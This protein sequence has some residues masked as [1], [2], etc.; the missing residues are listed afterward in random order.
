MEMEVL[1]KMTK[2]IG[3]NGGDG[4]FCPGGS[5]SNMMAMNLARYQYYPEVKRKGLAA[6]PAGL[7]AF[8]SDQVGCEVLHCLRLV[9]GGEPYKFL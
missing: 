1:R 7:C 3:F 4:V 2:A 8:T 6:A 9:H 5:T